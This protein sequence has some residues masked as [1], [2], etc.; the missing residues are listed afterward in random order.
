MTASQYAIQINAKNPNNFFRLVEDA[1]HWAAMG[2]HTGEE[3]RRFLAISEY[4]DSY[5][6]TRGFRPRRSW[7]GVPTEEIEAAVNN[8]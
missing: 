6:E 7:D 4:E 1:A 2:V 5:K 3:L 8:L